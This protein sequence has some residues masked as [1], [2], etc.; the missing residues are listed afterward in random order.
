MIINAT[1]MSPAITRETTTMEAR[2]VMDAAV[3]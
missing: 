1:A 3:G 2:R